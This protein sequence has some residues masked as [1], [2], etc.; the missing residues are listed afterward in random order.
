[1]IDLYLQ[2]KMQGEGVKSELYYFDL[3][4][5]RQCKIFVI[6]QQI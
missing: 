3:H 4:I 5:L 2:Q 1:M 6:L